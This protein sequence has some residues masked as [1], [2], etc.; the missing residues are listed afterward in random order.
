MICC[1]INEALC[2]QSPGPIVYLLSRVTDWANKTRRYVRETVCKWT[3]ATDRKWTLI[4]MANNEK[5][6][7][8]RTHLIPIT[9][10]HFYALLNIH[11]NFWKF[12]P[13][14]FTP[15]KR[16]RLM[17]IG[18]PI[19]IHYKRSR[20]PSQVYNGNRY[21]NKTVCFERPRLHSAMANI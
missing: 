2:P 8:I 18:T 13:S 12:Y 17:G 6:P 16:R 21:S 11:R 10:I 9:Y 7:R 5:I 3:E 20:Q 1:S 15:E 14:A 19:I 4:D